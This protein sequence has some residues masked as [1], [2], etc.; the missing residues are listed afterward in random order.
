[1][2]KNCVQCQS[3]FEVTDGDRAF[4]ERISPVF[5][6][7]KSLITEPTMCPPCRNQR[8]MAWRNDRTFYHRKCDLTGKQFIS[9][10]PAGTSFPVYMP[11]AWQSDGWDS[12]EFGRDVD[13][14]RSFFDQLNELFSVAP[15]LGVVIYNCENSDY[16]N[17]CTDEKNC[18]I[19]IAAE[20]NEDCYYNL[21][22]K[23][24]KN[25][26][27]TPRSKPAHSSLDYNLNIHP[28]YTQYTSFPKA[29]ED[30]E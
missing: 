1:M 23:Y 12:M 15:H 11:E 9:M 26:D 18:Y 17:Y 7:Q 20:S 16:C 27:N 4:L 13:L 19:D 5:K 24:S 25:I 30:Y 14:N 3:P 21:F 2:N 10:Y 28:Y 8:R 29:I 22:C 6:G